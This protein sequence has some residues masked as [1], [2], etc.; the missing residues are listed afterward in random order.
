MLE[1]VP[2]ATHASWSSAEVG[3]NVSCQPTAAS[4]RFCFIYCE[5]RASNLSLAIA[6]GCCLLWA[7]RADRGVRD[8]VG[9]PPT[10]VTV[11]PTVLVPG[12]AYT[13]NWDDCISGC[14][15]IGVNL[16]EVGVITFNQVTTQS[17]LYQPL[18]SMYSDRQRPS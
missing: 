14:E 1:L 11:T 2:R 15:I 10:N 8:Q 5:M 4:S 3:I 17:S 13:V 7:V 6:T 12:A 18:Q 9:L 16:M